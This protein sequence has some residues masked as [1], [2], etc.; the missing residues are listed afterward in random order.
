MQHVLQ[1]IFSSVCSLK[2]QHRQISRL[3]LFAFLSKFFC[4]CL[5]SYDEASH[6]LSQHVHITSQHF[7][8]EGSSALTNTS[9]LLGRKKFG[10]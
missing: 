7:H 1:V 2:L 3:P 8:I 6:F 4:N 9:V 10:H 5:P